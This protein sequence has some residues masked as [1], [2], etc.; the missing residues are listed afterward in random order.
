MFKVNLLLQNEED[1][2][3]ILELKGISDELLPAI[4]E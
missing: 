2:E 1:E 3:T 4:E